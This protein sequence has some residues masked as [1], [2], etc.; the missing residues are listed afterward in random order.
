MLLFLPHMIKTGLINANCIQDTILF[1]LHSGIL[2]A[3]NCMRIGAYINP[4]AD[5]GGETHWAGS[6]VGG[7]GVSLEPK[8]PSLDLRLTCSLIHLKMIAFLL[9]AICNAHAHITQIA[10]Y[11]LR[12]YLETESCT[13]L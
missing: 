11:Y 8:E 1:N 9:L 7:G 10:T 12:L 6:G 3:Q 5:K 2:H 4:V 13:K